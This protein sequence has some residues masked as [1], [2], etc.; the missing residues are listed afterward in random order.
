MT[1]MS[2]QPARPGHGASDW[3]DEWSSEADLAS[4]ARRRPAPAA[5]RGADLSV[6]EFARAL[7]EFE[8]E[9]AEIPLTPA[10]VQPLPEVPVAARIVPS[11][12]LARW[13]ATTVAAAVLLIAL[14]GLAPL[15]PP[16]VPP[17][18]AMPARLPSDVALP[19]E[20][21]AALLPPSLPERARAAL[22]DS[23]VPAS[24]S[25]TAMGTS[26]ASAIAPAR[27][28][29]GAPAA[30]AR[31]SRPPV[32]APVAF[33]QRG[34]QPPAPGL[35]LATSTGTERTGPSPSAAPSREVPPALLPPEPAPV[36]AAPAAPSVSAS[37]PPVPTARQIIYGV[38]AEYQG[39]L[40][41]LDAAAVRAIWPSVDAAS[42]ERAF[43]QLERQ[44]VLFD[45]CSVAIIGAG[46]TARCQGSS[47]YV[48]RVG[49]RTERLEPRHWRIELKQADATWQ[50]VAVDARE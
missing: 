49:R 8:P 25:R 22:D 32:V 3:A 7:A 29:D 11:R 35:V 15:P 30:P 10:V 16:R 43:T 12:A 27:V 46:A 18:A 5:S 13:L 14:A 19:A 39:A 24:V 50:I 1:P 44:S 20:P 2:P 28:G 40:N 48:P 38:L 34:S 17:G 23:S 33:A 6:D 47:S 45:A 9:A 41:R 42:L 21:A 26:E 37:A 31:T 36:A 4:P